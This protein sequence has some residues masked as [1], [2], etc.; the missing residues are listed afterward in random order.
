[1]FGRSRTEKVKAN[2]GRSAE[3]ALELAQDKRFRKQLLSAIKHGSQARRRAQ[4][5]LSTAAALRRLVSDRALQNELRRARDDL[6]K[7]HARVAAKQRAGRLR[8]LLLAAAV[9]SLAAFPSLRR[10]LSNLFEEVSTRS[11]FL[12]DF[13]PGGDGTGAVRQAARPRSLDDLSKEELYARAQ[14]ADIPGRSEMSKQDLVAALRAK[15]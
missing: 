12:R 1:L 4:N 14:E 15:S 3:L 5:S 2:A 7:A 8:K 11:Q 10:R 9:G 13:A 6:Q